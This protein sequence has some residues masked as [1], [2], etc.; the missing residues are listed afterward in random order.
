[1]ESSFVQRFSL[2]LFPAKFGPDVRGWTG[3]HQRR[4][5]VN[6]AVNAFCNIT[7]YI[8]KRLTK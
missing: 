4:T 7:S 3:G 2:Q 6:G 5:T 8:G 1:M